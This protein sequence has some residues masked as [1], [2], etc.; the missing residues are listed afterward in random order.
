MDQIVNQ[1][2]KFRYMFGGKSRCPRGHSLFFGRRIQCGGA[3]QS[4]DVS[5]D[6]LISR[7]SRSWFPRMPMMPRGSC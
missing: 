5:S 3:A 4:G 2:A 6:D 7:V 1:M